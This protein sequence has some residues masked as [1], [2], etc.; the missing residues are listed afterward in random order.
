MSVIKSYA[1]GDGDMFTINHNSSNFT[2]IDCYLSTENK[3][4]VIYEI[5]DQCKTKRITRSISTHP[6]EDH[7]CGLTDLDKEIGIVNFYC[8]KNEATKKDES[9]DFTKYCE[10]RDS[11]KAFY[12]SKGCTR[13]YMNKED[14]DIKSSGIQILW[15]DVNN[16]FYKD[17]L[18][19]AKD[20][21]SPNNISAVIKY[22]IS[23][24][25]VVV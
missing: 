4:S 18:Q 3:K 23:N 7:V 16:E 10:F 1:V 5:I 15:P 22:S 9:P 20:G 12:I 6:D 14:D 17:A 11:D 13:K 19:V 24:G 2:I 21:G 25:P 8:V